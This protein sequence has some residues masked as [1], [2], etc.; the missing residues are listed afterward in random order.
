VL[1]EAKMPALG[2][3]HGMEAPAESEPVGEPG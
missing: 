1:M 2:G 3:A